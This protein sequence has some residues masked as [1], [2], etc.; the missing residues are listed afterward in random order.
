MKLYV[1]LFGSPD[2][3]LLAGTPHDGKQ[4]KRYLLDDGT[5]LTDPQPVEAV[6]GQ[7]RPTT[8]EVWEQAHPRSGNVGERPTATRGVV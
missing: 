4:H 2:P 5:I 3:L 1:P 6:K 7:G 8:R